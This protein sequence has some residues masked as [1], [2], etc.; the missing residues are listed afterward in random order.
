MKKY[1]SLSFKDFAHFGRFR[2]KHKVA[3]TPINK[4]RRYADYSCSL[5]GGFLNTESEYKEKGAW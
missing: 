4:N 1:Y 5:F 3:L 2:V